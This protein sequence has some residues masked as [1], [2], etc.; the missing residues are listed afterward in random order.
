MT[1]IEQYRFVQAH[2]KEVIKED[3][4]AQVCEALIGCILAYI[5]FFCIL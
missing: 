5:M 3:R 1:L 4:K 2:A